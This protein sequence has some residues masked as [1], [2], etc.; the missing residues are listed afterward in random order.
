MMLSRNKEPMAPDQVEIEAN[1]PET[2][3]RGMAAELQ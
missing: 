1:C 3:Y 2:Y